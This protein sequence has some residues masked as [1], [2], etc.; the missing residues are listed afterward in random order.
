LSQIDIENDD[1]DRKTYL[2]KGERGRK[3]LFGKKVQTQQNHFVGGARGTID[4]MDA[5]TT[6]TVLEIKREECWW[7]KLPKWKQR[8]WWR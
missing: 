5:Y 4:G 7:W 6:L 2:I 3:S 1:L 8:L